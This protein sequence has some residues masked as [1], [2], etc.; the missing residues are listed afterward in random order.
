MRGCQASRFAATYALIAKS[1]VANSISVSACAE[2]IRAIWLETSVSV[3]SYAS[4]E[5]ILALPPSPRLRPASMS[6][7][8]SEFS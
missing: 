7:P 3:V 6:L 5:T 1:G 2:R 8:K 4:C